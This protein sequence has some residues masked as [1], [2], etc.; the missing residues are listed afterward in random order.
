MNPEGAEKAANKQRVLLQQMA[1]FSQYGRVMLAVQL[2]E[3]EL[4]GAAMLGSVKDPFAPVRRAN[5][6]RT[7]KRFL[8]RVI[9]LSFRATAAEARDSAAKVLSV[10]LME[11]VDR[12]IKW[13]NRLAHRYLREKAAGSVNGEFAP[14]TYDELVKLAH[15]FDNLGKRLAEETE[16]IRSSWP[17]DNPPPP[18]VAEALEEIAMRIAKGEPPPKPSE[19]SRE[20]A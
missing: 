12:A 3:A 17:N 1:V 16:R 15:S 7:I 2:F 20:V 5:V 19:S 9:H 4:S 13:R 18:Q 11:E 14:G 8:K 6:Q 10:D